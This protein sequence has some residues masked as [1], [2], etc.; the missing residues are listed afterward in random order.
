MIPVSFDVLIFPGK[1]SMGGQDAYVG[2]G[3]NYLA[4]K[5]GRNQ[6]SFGAE[7]FIGVQ[8]DPMGTGGKTFIEVGYSM[9]RTGGQA[10]PPLFSLKGIYAMIGFKIS[11]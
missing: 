1:E 8:G 11:M 4:Y 10:S 5:S 3:L 9:L 2:G 7:A 6:G